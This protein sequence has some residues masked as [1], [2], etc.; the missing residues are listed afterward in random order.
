MVPLHAACALLRSFAAQ[1]TR[2]LVKSRTTPPN[3]CALGPSP[4]KFH[5]RPVAR[6]RGL[7]LLLISWLLAWS[8]AAQAQSL[9][10]L[11]SGNKAQPAAAAT[12]KADLLKRTTPRS[13]I[14]A[15]LEAC[16][17]GKY[18]LAAQYLDLRNMSTE[19]RS[20]QGPELAK[21]LQLLLNRN[22]G[23][24]VSHLS[25]SAEG[26]TE[27]GLRPYTDSLAIFEEDGAAVVLE[28]QRVDLN[29]NPLWLVSSSSVGRI[30]LLA[31][32]V[33]DNVIEKR[34]PAPLVKIQLLGTPLWICIALVLVG[35]ILS[36]ISRWLSLLVIALL[37]PLTKK[38][39]KSFHTQRLEA[40]TEPLRL[41]LSVVVF[42]ATLA[43]IPPSAL[44]RDDLL[45]LLTLLFMLGAASLVMRLV[46][47]VSDTVVSRL[48][49]RERALTYSIFPLVIR[50]VKI[51][52]FCLAVLVVLQQWGYNTSAI[53]AGVGVGGVAV[54]LAAQKT[55]E[56]L[57]G[58]VAVITD[59]P[60]L[61]GDF[62]QFGGQLGTVED[63]GL[64]STRIRT[65]NRTL[66]TVPNSQFSTMT[67]ENYSKRDR[68]W[69]HPKISLRR[70]TRPEEIRQMMAAI[71]E[72]LDKHSM[73]DASGVP[74]RFTQI[75]DQSLD[76]EIFAYVLTPDSNEYLK[77]QTDLLLQILEA[78]TRIGVGLAVPIQEEYN[79]SV[80][81]NNE[82]AR[83]PNLA[84]QN[85]SKETVEGKAAEPSQLQR[86]N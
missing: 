75:S 50:F 40:L 77:V 27:D 66:V 23:F 67:L 64:R 4:P 68:M 63:I 80:T 70:D 15:F 72:I 39:A 28:M 12:A 69:F 42:R 52:I 78:A 82:N 32:N 55:I 48:D 56:N 45:K 17:A 8:P 22:P 49:P 9:G 18:A 3:S 51:G 71:A 20:T 1:R 57:F 81:A 19:Q 10:N 41:L 24:E 58:G 60:V 73:V 79:V 83:F 43:F 30:P 31:S 38:Y 84:M 65:L 25:D 29:G 26:N 76:L 34:L 53:L 33:G 13:S 47:V 62:C 6:D 36:A 16:H 2:P 46:D 5:F 86:T 7:C 61:V 85:G 35:L 44:L 54:A 74:L 14:Y 21:Q 59:R 11:L 37:K